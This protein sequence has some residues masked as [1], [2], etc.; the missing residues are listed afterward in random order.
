MAVVRSR[1]IELW[2]RSLQAVA[3]KDRRCNTA[4]QVAV[5]LIERPAQMVRE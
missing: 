4:T 1:Q 5:C 3:I 2:G